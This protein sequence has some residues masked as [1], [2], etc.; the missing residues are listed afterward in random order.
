MRHTVDKLHASLSTVLLAPDVQQ[1]MN[2]MVIDAAPSSPEEFAS[3]IRSETN[4]WAK[5][6]KDAGI[7]QQ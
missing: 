4:R 5:V 7:A 1:R 6:I 3:F 2:D